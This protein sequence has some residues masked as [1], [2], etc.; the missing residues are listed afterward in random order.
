MRWSNLGCL[1]NSQFLDIANVIELMKQKMAE[2]VVHDKF[3][4]LS[5]RIFRLLLM[6]KQLDQKPVCRIAFELLKL[7]YHRL[8]I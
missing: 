1:S 2:S 3:G 7:T 6:K 4:P 5:M 8:Q